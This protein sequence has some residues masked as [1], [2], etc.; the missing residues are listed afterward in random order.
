MEIELQTQLLPVQPVR[1][2]PPPTYVWD[3]HQI[4][5]D[6]TTWCRVWYATTLSKGF[7]IGC[8]PT[9]KKLGT[10]NK[11]LYLKLNF[12]HHG[13]QSNHNPTTATVWRGRETRERKT[14]SKTNPRSNLVFK[15]LLS[16][17]S[18]GTRRD[19]ILA[20]VALVD[21]LE[22]TLWGGTSQPHLWP[23]DEQPNRFN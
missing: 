3:H 5:S 22:D 19:L 16:P 10:Y 15:G 20:R 11:T 7:R 8:S 21:S 6:S 2:P 14:K 13:W 9:T 1:M 23:A 4:C 18:K 12:I 17:L